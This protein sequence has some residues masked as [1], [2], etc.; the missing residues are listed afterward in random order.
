MNSTIQQFLRKS[1]ADVVIVGAGL[2]G[3]ECAW[4]LLKKGF[5]V[6]LIEQ[7]PD[8]KSEAH[9]GALFGE[10]VC[11]NSLKSTEP[12][13]APQLLKTELER[14]GSLV[15]SSAYET[16][17][18]AGQSLAVDRE[19]FSAL[20]TERLKSHPKL[21]LCLAG[22][23]NVEELFTSGTSGL[24]PVV[25]ATGP[26]T[27]DSLATSLGRLI[28][29][30]LYFYDAIAPI[31]AGHS[32]DRNKAFLQNRY[33][34]GVEAGSDG[35]YLNCPLE[36]EEYFKFIEALG[37]GEKVAPHD[38]EKAV[39]FQGCQPI[40]AML[41]RGP[42]TLAHGPMKPVG[43]T[44]P[45][46]GKQAF[47]IVQ[48]RKEDEEGRAWNMVGFQTKL[49]YPGQ[50]KIF[51]L[52]PGLENAEFYRFGSLHRNTYLHSPVVLD[53]QFRLKTHPTI[54]FAGQI[55]GVEGYLESTAIG[56]LVGR[57]LALRLSGTASPP[58][59]PATTA[60]GA[61]AH[62]IVN[63]KVNNFQPMNINWGLVPLSGI[64]ERDKEKKQKMTARAERQFSHWLAL[65]GEA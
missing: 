59:P 48:L 63:G 32:I 56:A 42:L 22:V 2:A 6:A 27:H 31:I 58:L 4:Q 10:L 47:A 16:K 36:K 13:S 8:R 33:D 30:R 49:K 11:S 39:Y 45:R 40:E 55:T 37:A 29:E 19:K 46:T 23:D 25:L 57:M 12:L 15:L 64:D 62:A 14:L 3:S 65:F 5:R 9:T 20:I 50:K 24:R 1:T 18:P 7:R 54:H 51:S 35:D 28:G 53:Q 21:E 44:N 41:E 43:I 60:I 17:I 38:F 52:I 34:K 61:L 26:L